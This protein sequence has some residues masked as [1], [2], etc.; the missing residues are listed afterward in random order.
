MERPDDY[1]A[2]IIK[3]VFFRSRDLGNL[4]V[5][6][7]VTEQICINLDAYKSKVNSFILQLEGISFPEQGRTAAG[8]IFKIIGNRLPKSKTS[9][10]Y[11]ILSQ[12]S[13]LVT[14]GKYTYES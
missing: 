6:P 12:D 4:I 3:P 1:K 13:E 7:E 5:H 8:V 14:T 2:N 9:G 11:Y 10:L